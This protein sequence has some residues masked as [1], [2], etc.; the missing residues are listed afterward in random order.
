MK[1]FTTFLMLFVIVVSS[2]FAQN[3]SEQEKVQLDQERVQIEMQNYQPVN[4]DDFTSNGRNDRIDEYITI[5]DGTGYGSWPAYYSPFGNYWENGHTQSL[6]LASELG[7][8]E[9]LITKLAWF[10]ERVAPAG[11]DF[12]NNLS[13]KVMEVSD[14]ELTT[15]DYY[16]VSG[17]TEVF[18][19]SSMT[20]PSETGWFDFDVDDFTYSGTQNLLIDINWGDNGYYDANYFRTLKTEMGSVRTLV[21]Y[22][23]SETPPNYDG[24]A[25]T[26]DNLRITH[27]VEPTEPIFAIT[28]ETYTFGEVGILDGE[29]YSSELADFMVTNEG[30]GT[31]NITEEP[32]FFS[33]QDVNFNYVGDATFPYPIDGIY[34]DTGESFDFQVEFAPSIA[35]PSTTLL[36]VT[37]DLG[38]VTRTFELNGTAYD[39]PEYDVMENAYMIEQDWL[40]NNDFNTAM[41]FDD[42][43][44]DYNLAP[45]TD[46]VYHFDVT[47]DSY[48]DFVDNLGS[49]NDFSVFA[50]GDEFTAANDLY[51]GSQLAIDA[52]S[53]YVVASGSGEFDFDIHI[54]GQEPVLVVDPTTMDLGDVPIGCWHEGGT[55]EVYNDGG[56]TITFLDAT[57]SDENG[58]YTLTHDYEFPITISTE[59]LQFDVALEADTEGIF[60]GAFLLE[61]ENTTYIYPIT[62]NAY[63]PVL[64]DVIC[65]PVI[66]T[67]DGTGHF[68][69]DNSVAAP[70]HDNY[71]LTDGYNDVVYKFSYAS[72][73]I[74]D[75]AL[76]NAVMD[77][78][79][80]I[81]SA[82]DVA[83]TDP[84]QLEP[85]AAGG[86]EILDQELWGGT[87]YL[88]VAGDQNTTPEYMLTM[89]VEDMPAPGAVTLL[90][91]ADGTD[92][93]TIDPTLT[94]ELGEYT[95][96]IDVYVDTQYPP[97]DKVLGNGIPVETFDVEGL[98][99]AQI[100]FWKVVAHNDSGSTESETWAFTTMLPPPL[101][102]QG[103]I[104]DYVNVHLT[105]NSPFDATYRVKEDFENGEMPEG[106][107][108]S[109][110][111]TG[112]S[113]G[114][115]ITDA[116]GSG[117]FS[118]PAH[119]IYAVSNDD[120]NN[121]DGSEDYL[122][123]PSQD[124]SQ[125]DGAT[126]S[127]ESFYNGD[128][129]QMAYVEISTDGGDTFEV[130]QELDPNDA[131]TTITVE[132]AD[133][134]DESDVVIA[135][136][137]DD[138]G[139][140]AS[141]WAVDDV[142]LAFESNLGGGSRALTG[143][144]V[145]QNGSM[146]NDEL[147]TV[148]EYD[149]MD[150]AAGDY[151]FGVSAVYDEGESEI[152]EIETIT[153]LG[154]SEIAGTVTDY[155]TGDPIEG[156]NIEIMGM[157]DEEE[158]E[159][160][161][162][163]DADG[164]YSQELPVTLD[165]Y[166]V[167]ASASGY[168]AITEEDVMPAAAVTEVVDFAMGEFP[169]PASNV[170][171][172]SNDDE[173]VATV[174]WD[175]PSGFPSYEII[176]DDGIA[177]NATAWNPGFEGNMNALKFTP[178]GYP[179]TINEVM[180]HIWDGTWPAGDVFNPMEVVILDD[181]GSG[182]MP[183]T[184]LGSIEVTPTSAN[185]VTVDLSSLNVTISDGEFY[186]ANRQIS[187]YPDCPP[188]GIAEGT[189]QNRSYSYTGGAWGTATYDSFMFRATVSGP[190]GT[191][192][193]VTKAITLM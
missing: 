122:Y 64:G 133:Y 117:S 132:L 87:Y 134:M 174:T 94:W 85:V 29:A 68:E 157:W 53:Y 147:V 109:T 135:F 141:G 71:H 91:P 57:L 8:E 124:F 21:G 193:L 190:Q 63:T 95:N 103:T 16:D 44:S 126:L 40:V 167:T 192:S 148:E 5:G 180:V 155:V 136:H 129:S 84:D 119:T 78:H 81:Y 22:A 128:Y 33:G 83:T 4:L 160:S 50:D 73:F 144:N 186:I 74:I 26:V 110:V 54:E 130:V 90:T 159:Y 100:Y 113:A 24:D 30:I 92:N 19:S 28:P 170:V 179:C 51:T 37:D 182:G 25:T 145:W 118:I 151:V 2:G 43:Y 56:Q 172:V 10:F 32:Y 162:S 23:D 86:Q 108:M 178:S 131:W 62:G 153:I 27:Y 123:M 191:E 125:W 48:V 171:A 61:D 76:D 34:D 9:I 7:E 112:S 181:D 36:V 161:V 152:T 143:Y 45:S 42:F 164:Y 173:T 60:E 12:W 184:E 154:M 79:M 38:R 55:F 93:V 142:E 111:A 69:D 70:M 121:D 46:V 89:D 140:W 88:V 49:V 11:E 1:K 150:L 97:Q 104:F 168:V 75:I 96:N 3:L 183:G 185:W 77:P 101:F 169:I 116:G 80:E 187:V 189:P 47:I 6:Y 65:D 13:I 67:F 137:A 127:F 14:A 105:W 102:V 15:G 163:T 149:V 107:S 120:A 35:G 52:G 59:T 139:A 82:G 31:I 165:G 175:T 18:S 158:L 58:V 98:S 106:W 188:T 72:D 41:N 17:A 138:A 99:P 177:T 66:A 176:Y 39:I 156:A 20:G 166:D 115:F 114:W 146:I